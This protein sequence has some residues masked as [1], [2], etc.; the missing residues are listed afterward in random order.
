MSTEV[1]VI[2]VSC[3]D[4]RILIAKSGKKTVR[5]DTPFNLVAWIMFECSI[6]KFLTIMAI[7]HMPPHISNIIW[8]WMNEW[9]K[10]PN[11]FVAV[12]WKLFSFAFRRTQ[13]HLR[14]IKK[15]LSCHWPNATQCTDLEYNLNW[16]TIGIKREA[17]LSTFI[18]LAFLCRFDFLSF[19][20]YL[21]WV[22]SIRMRRENKWSCLWINIL[23]L[24]WLGAYLHAYQFVTS[25]SKRIEMK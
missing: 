13:T 22:R 15:S 23:L 4:F 24:H 6:L 25:I 2:F 11:Q 18:Y 3:N 16:A 21:R 12:K 9:V 17:E 8:L 7:K 10:L 1:A 19:E 14:S 20:K 5:I